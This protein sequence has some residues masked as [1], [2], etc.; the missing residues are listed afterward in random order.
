M[1]MKIV[2]KPLS[3]TTLACVERLARKMEDFL[4]EIEEDEIKSGG[5]MAS[6][7]LFKS[8]K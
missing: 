1:D 7:L 8:L 4:K 6:M 2:L 5:N 3:S